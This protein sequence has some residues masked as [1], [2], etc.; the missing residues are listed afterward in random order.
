MKYTNSNKILGAVSIFSLALSYASAGLTQTQ[1]KTV[2]TRTTTQRVT[3][4]Q[5]LK[6]AQSTDR[7][8]KANLSQKTNTVL[9]QSQFNFQ[10]PKENVDLSSVKPARTSD[11]L[12]GEN[13]NQ[14]EYEKTLD[15][16]INELFKLTQ[17]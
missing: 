4:G 15:V 9:P 3:V 1:R 17:K 16:Q 13:N 12:R 6:K 8:G 2:T 7:G 5:M 14:I 11:I 10:K